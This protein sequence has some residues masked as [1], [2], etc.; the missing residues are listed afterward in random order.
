VRYR[1]LD[2]IDLDAVKEKVR[3]WMLAHPT[4]TADQMTA[5]LKGDYPKFPDH[6][7]IVLRGVM[8]SL[9]DYP[10]ELD[11]GQPPGHPR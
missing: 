1:D 2:R 8:A 3:Q 6:M 4:G 7:A 9:Q 10:A 5:D 11:P